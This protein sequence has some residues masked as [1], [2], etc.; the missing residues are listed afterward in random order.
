M[1]GDEHQNEWYIMIQMRAFREPYLV[2]TMGE[3]DFNFWED[4]WSNGSQF[5]DDNFMMNLRIE[6][7]SACKNTCS[8]VIADVNDAL[9]WR[10][11]QQSH[12]ES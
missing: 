8:G 4:F 12:L 1:G 10:D 2:L 5:W 6:T 9:R 3:A 7:K 11:E